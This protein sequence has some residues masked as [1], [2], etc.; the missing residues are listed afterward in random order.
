M[1][2]LNLKGVFFLTQQLMPL[3][4]A[5]ATAER[6]SA[7]INMSSIT[8]T[9]TGA[10][11]D[12]S[13]RAS[14]AGLNQLTRMLAKHLARENVNVNAISPGFFR[15]SLTEFVFEDEDLY[16][17][18]TRRM[19]IPRD[20]RPAEIAGLALYLASPA[21]GYMTGAILEIDGGLR[22]ID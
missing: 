9:K 13:Y 11:G 22:F 3:L 18:V 4:T 17:R 14:K 2:D 19:P 5:E 15:S 6:R 12:Y 1:I 16:E 21:G 7:V 8:A 10:R 20:G